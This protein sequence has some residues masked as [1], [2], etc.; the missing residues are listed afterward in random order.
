MRPPRHLGVN[1]GGERLVHDPEVGHLHRRPLGLVAQAVAAFAP[2]RVGI[3]APLASPP[4]DPAAIE[5]VVQD[6]DELLWVAADG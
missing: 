1:G 2:V 5:R 3:L 4:D 6:A